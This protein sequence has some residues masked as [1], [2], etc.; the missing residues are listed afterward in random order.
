M[1]LF[2]V[3]LLRWGMRISQDAPMRARTRKIRD[4]E[5]RNRNPPARTRLAA[6]RYRDA[7]VATL[8]FASGHDCVS[9]GLMSMNTLNSSA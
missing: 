5:D 9:R 6:C 3:E 7:S 8:P 2:I 4:G 1:S